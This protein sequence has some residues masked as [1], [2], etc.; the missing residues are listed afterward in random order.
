MS[1]LQETDLNNADGH[2][3]IRLANA[4]LEQTGWRRRRRPKR[5]LRD[6]RAAGNRNDG[7]SNVGRV[8][9]GAAT[10]HSSTPGRNA[11]TQWQSTQ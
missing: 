5:R 11:R 2:P 1:P 3:P 9:V 8:V 7:R 6:G 10:K 4:K